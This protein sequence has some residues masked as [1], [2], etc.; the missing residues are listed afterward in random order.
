MSERKLPQSK[1]QQSIATTRSSSQSSLPP[2][3][4]SGSIDNLL[5]RTEKSL[6]DIQHSIKVN[7]FHMRK[8]LDK[9]NVAEAITYASLM[10]NEL[11]SNITPK[12]YY[13]VYISVCDQLRHFQGYLS[14]KHLTEVVVKSEDSLPE[15]ASAG[16]GAGVE[17]EGSKDVQAN[18]PLDEQESTEQAAQLEQQQAQKPSKLDRVT[19]AKSSKLSEFYQLVQYIPQL[20]P[21]LYLM[22]TV[23]SVYLKQ[24]YAPKNELLTDMLE[25]CKGVQNPIRGLFLR[26][27]LQQV[28]KE[29]MPDTKESVNES[30]VFILSNFT[31]MNKLWVRLQYQGHSKE[32]EKRTQE[33]K[34]LKLLVG[35]NLVRLSQLESLTKDDYIVKILPKILEQIVVCKDVLAQEYLMEALIQVFPD[36]YNLSSLQLLLKSVGELHPRVNIKNIIISFI[37]RFSAGSNEDGSKVQLGLFNVFYDQIVDIVKNRTE[38]SVNDAIQLCTSLTNLIL[39]LNETEKVDEQLEQV[40]FV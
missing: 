23:G 2:N 25:M 28:T 9:S 16:A 27:Y 6:D 31:E 34:E 12:E 37:D 19:T 7:A 32:R 5:N 10:L 20:L 15:I 4:H 21:R 29:E 22:L 39:K 30:F 26:Y 11:A 14:E 40:S 17:A 13:E 3:G 33:R 18:S 35:F 36:E 1:S 8:S 24:K 38:L